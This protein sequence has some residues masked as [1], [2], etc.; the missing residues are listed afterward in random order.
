[1]AELERKFKGAEQIYGILNFNHKFLG[2]A[3][4]CPQTSKMIISVLK[5]LYLVQFNP[6]SVVTSSQLWFI[7]INISKNLIATKVSP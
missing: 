5:L 4:L 3:Q 2:E 7:K 6:L 1:M